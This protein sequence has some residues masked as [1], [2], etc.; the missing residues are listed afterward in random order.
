MQNKFIKGDV[1]M[2]CSKCGK[3]LNN[4]AK[5]CDGC[6]EKID[7]KDV[8]TEGNTKRDVPKCTH[9]GYEGNWKVGPVFRPI[10]W[11]IRIIFA[12]MGIIPGIIY[13]GVVGAIRSNEDNREKICPKCNAKN[14]WT[15]FY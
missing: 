9:C 12:F 8:K 6:G 13:L 14:L 4:D 11:I 10:D 5:F 2:Y 15:F 3:E 7:N 1:Y